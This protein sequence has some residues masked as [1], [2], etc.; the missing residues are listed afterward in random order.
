MLMGL[1]GVFCIAVLIIVVVMVFQDYFDR[2]DESQKQKNKVQEKN[3]GAGTCSKPNCCY[4]YHRYGA[5]S[6]PT[7]EDER[8]L[9]DGVT[10]VLAD[11]FVNV[12]EDVVDA[13]AT[14]GYV[15]TVEDS[16]VD[17]SDVNSYSTPSYDHLAT[18][19]YESPAVSYESPSSSYDSSPS[20]G[21]SNAG[22][23]NSSSY[24]SFSDMS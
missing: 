9:D 7:F 24:D 18:P 22:C 6:T 15:Q 14:S 16:V 17:S 4:Q 12:V 20:Y 11:T 8:F 3:S 5:V 2:V 19:S 10:E 13:I 23:D 1:L 21:D